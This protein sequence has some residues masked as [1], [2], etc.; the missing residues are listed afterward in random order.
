MR[1]PYSKLKTQTLRHQKFQVQDIGRLRFRNVCCV[2]LKR[3]W[4]VGG[5]GRKKKGGKPG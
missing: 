2:R 3:Y 4:V 1:V 5:F